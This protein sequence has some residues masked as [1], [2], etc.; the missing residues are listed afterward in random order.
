M[1][2]ALI[3][4]DYYFL[5][6]LKSDYV[7]EARDW[8]S[9]C[10]FVREFLSLVNK[11]NSFLFE[12]VFFKDR[13]IIIH[14]SPSTTTSTIQI[15]KYRSECSLISQTLELKRELTAT[16]VTIDGFFKSHYPKTALVMYGRSG[17]LHSKYMY[18]ETENP[19]TINFLFPKIDAGHETLEVR[20]LENT[21]H[22]LVCDTFNRLS[23]S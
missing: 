15:Y 9:I 6:D 13:S 11:K 8:N 14:V 3:G 23:A 16:K 10:E 4:F 12:C 2:A 1:D 19:L 7:G 21:I 5:K 18:K 22:L 20:T 17:F